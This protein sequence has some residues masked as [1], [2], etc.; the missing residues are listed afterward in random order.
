VDR[1]GYSPALDGL[2]GVA[3]LLV[4]GSHF[5]LPGFAGGGL[6]GVTLFFV[7]SGY[8]ITSLLLAERNSTGSVSLRAFYVRRGARLF[9]ALALVLTIVGAGLLAAGE[10]QVAANGVGYSAI[11]V[12]NLAVAAGANL[13]PLEHTWSPAIEEQFYLVWPAV[14]L[15]LAGRPR[16]L[17][18]GVGAVIALATVLRFGGIDNQDHLW[19]AYHST[20]TRI[21][22]ILIG[23]LLAFVT[24]RPTRALAL[25]AAVFLGLA[26]V[27]PLSPGA[28]IVYLLLPISLAGGLLVLTRPGLLAWPPLVA[29]G[30][31]SYGLYLWHFPLSAV[32]PAW[33]AIPASFAVAAASYRFLEQP[34]RRWARRAARGDN[35]VV[36]TALAANAPDHQPIA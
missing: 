30:T 4:M 21:D 8:L 6:V 19:V 25:T 18:V 26:V 9:P 22:A 15:V 13:G 2:R 3:V 5:A 35:P 34:I 7:L 28:L 17:W 11:Y 24:W 23:C 32:L 29:I 27:L 1:F 36:A 14:L 31:I 16:V 33:A 20:A 10:R 12:S